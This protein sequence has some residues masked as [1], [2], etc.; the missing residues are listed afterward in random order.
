MV[1]RYPEAA[2]QSQIAEERRGRMSGVMS[3]LRQHYTMH[4]DPRREADVR[5]TTLLHVRHEGDLVRRSP[6]GAGVE[7][8]TIAARIMATGERCGLAGQGAAH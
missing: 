7:V 5:K 4:V 8:L 3:Y 6:G 1:Y 2:P